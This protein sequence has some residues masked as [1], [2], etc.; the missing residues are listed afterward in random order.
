MQQY[1]HAVQVLDDEYGIEEGLMSTVHATTATQKTVDGPS[2]KDWRGGR[3]AS[4]NI[5]PS[6]TGVR[7]WPWSPVW[8]HLCTAHQCLSGK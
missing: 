5:I 7:S 4:G 6:S 2:G 8:A 3:A 1:Q